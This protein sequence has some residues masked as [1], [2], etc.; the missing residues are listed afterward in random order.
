M[1]AASIMHNAAAAMAANPST[2]MMIVM[3][4]NWR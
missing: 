4:A 1:D 2:D 3:I